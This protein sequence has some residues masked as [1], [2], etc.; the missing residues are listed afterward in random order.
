MITQAVGAYDGDVA[1][2]SGQQVMSGQLSLDRGLVRLDFVNGASLAVEGPAK[3]EVVDKMRV[4]LL[5]GVVTAR[6]PESAIDFVVDTDTAHVVDLGTAFGVA[7]GNDGTTDVCVFEGEV[8]VSRKGSTSNQPTLVREG[9][10][11]R[12]SEQSPTIDSTDYEVAPFENAW[13]VNSG[14]LQTTGSI[15]LSLPAPTSIRGN[16]ED[17]E[18]IVVF[19]ERS[20]FI[21]KK[22]FEWIWWIRGNMPSQIMTRSLNCHLGGD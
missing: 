22:P 19:P 12:A 8:S 17:N 5:R 9:Q 1:I 10:A 2:R 14:V 6:I 13:P 18:H 21:R 20:G 3:I 15:R 16:Y 4:I 7:V 11:V